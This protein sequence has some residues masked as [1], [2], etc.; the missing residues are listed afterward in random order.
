MD[1]TTGPPS[2]FEQR[3]IDA[4]AAR[5][6]EMADLNAALQGAFDD[7]PAG[8]G[9]SG[10]SDEDSADGSG[11]GAEHARE[12]EGRRKLRDK[13]S[14]EKADVLATRASIKSMFPYLEKLSNSTDKTAYAAL[15][16]CV[17]GRLRRIDSRL[18]DPYIRDKTPEERADDVANDTKVDELYEEVEEYVANLAGANAGLDTTTFVC[19]YCGFT[20]SEVVVHAHA[21]SC[22]ADSDE[23]EP[24]DGTNNNI[25]GRAW[26]MV[27][28][29][30]AAWF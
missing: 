2:P 12:V 8:A 10:E 16:N 28:G 18:K 14:E 25:F 30:F 6:Q 23:G 19:P 15:L 24:A 17:N 1:W 4:R 11:M 5:Q 20:G 26:Q 27:Q 9:G 13:A 22:N 3:A 29:P 21:L 7:D